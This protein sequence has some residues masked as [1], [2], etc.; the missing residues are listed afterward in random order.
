MY[1]HFMHIQYNKPKNFFIQSFMRRFI[2][3]I[4]NIYTYL[5]AH[6]VTCLNSEDRIFAIH[7]DIST[8][9]I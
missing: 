7:N 8:T 1:S 5:V 6:D 2:S 9:Y 3:A 4:L